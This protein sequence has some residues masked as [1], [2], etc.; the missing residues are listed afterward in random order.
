MYLPDQSSIGDE[1]TDG[2]SLIVFSDKTSARRLITAIV[3]GLVGAILLGLATEYSI[4][5]FNQARAKARAARES[6]LALGSFVRTIDDAENSERGYIL[7]GNAD[8]LRNYKADIANYP[9]QYLHAAEITDARDRPSLDSL[10]AKGDAKVAALQSILAINQ[11][12]GIDAA[13]ASVRA[14]IVRNSGSSVDSSAAKLIFAEQQR[15]DS[16]VGQVNSL[17]DTIVAF[18]ALLIV[19][20]LSLAMYIAWNLARDQEPRAEAAE[21][22]HIQNDDLRAKWV[23]L[24]VANDQLEAT[25]KRFESLFRGVPVSCYFAGPDGEILE[26]NSASEALFGYST[27]EATRTTVYETIVRTGAFARTQSLFDGVMSG[28]AF[29]NIEWVCKTRDGRELEVMSNLLPLV[30]DSGEPIGIMAATIDM[31]ERKAVERLKSEFVSTVSHE[32]RTPLT[33]IRGALALVCSGALGDMSEQAKRLCGIANSNTERLVRLIND[34]LDIEK[35]ESGGITFRSVPFSIKDFSR[36][37]LNSM[38]GYAE[39]YK[40]ELL[41]ECGEDDVMVT[42]DPDRLMQVFN[43]VVSNAI[44]FSG[45]GKK[46]T[47]RLIVS[48]SSVRFAV[49]DKGPGIAEE[50][51]KRIFTKFAQGDSADTRKVGG[52]GLGLSISKAIIERLNGRI[53]FESGN[54]GT[55]FFFE[56]PLST[57]RNNSLPVDRPSKALICDGDKNFVNTLLV[58][59]SQ[60]GILAHVSYTA[61]HGKQLLAQERYDVLILDVHL[62]DQDGLEFLRDVRKQ[63]ETEHLPVVIVAGSRPHELK[64]INGDAIVD[65][66]ARTPLDSNRFI[67]SVLHAVSLNVR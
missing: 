10:K 38:K 18:V 15:F 2:E 24:N 43:N 45:E 14:D 34:L 8:L 57:E 36:N 49:Q 54:L 25:L 55:T 19:L 40:V 5:N 64:S 37:A 30:G 39:E 7:S 44:K 16:L 47:V 35:I 62:P 61:A 1:I 4:I 51:R 22:L 66:I 17:N 20:E 3:I 50:F 46:V 56:L 59:L 52:T 60:K 6:M 48:K 63:P 33:S 31:T 58:L 11:A 28:Q 26:W 9:R 23:A 41:S 12:R 67:D 65:W 53:W 21:T 29:E 32:L 13:R 27:A 42:S